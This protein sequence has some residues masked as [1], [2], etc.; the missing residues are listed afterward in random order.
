MVKILKYFFQSSIKKSDD[1]E[2]YKHQLESL[3]K[4]HY[5]E[6][7]EKIDNL[8]SDVFNIMD[9]FVAYIDFIKSSAKISVLNGYCK[10]TIVDNKYGYV[11]ATKMR[12]PIVER[13]IDYEYVPHDIELGKDLKG[14]LMYGLNSSG[15]TVIMKALGLSIIMAQCGLYV[16]AKEFILSPYHALYTRITGDDNI[17]RGLSSY[18][19][20]MSELNSIL[21][22]TGEFTMVIGDEVCRGTESISGNA[23]VASAII[24][25]A[26]TNSSFIF[27]T[28]LHEIMGLKDIKKLTNVKAFHLNVSYDEKSDTLIYDRII[29]EGSGNN[30]YGITVARHIIQDKEF[31][32]KANEIKNELLE[33]TGSIIS[34]K[35][36][37]Y[38]SNVYISECHV[39]GKKDKNSHISN[40]ETHHINFQKDCE[41]GLVKDK[42]HLK[43]NQEAN[44]IVLCN[45]CHDKIHSGKLLLDKYVMTSKG[46]NIIIKENK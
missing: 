22:R 29:K 11:C 38:N 15:K 39:C 37:R 1:I 3:N 21:K 40:L 33:Q 31:I 44:L 9:N 43:K 14:M 8:F 19:L 41:N 28:H 24:K 42:K 17:F 30:L 13:I 7:L 23:I 18:T 45:E 46:K 34:T 5:I 32:D 6:E 27:A 2:K 35:T 20:E 10:P 25:L 36:S 12:H 16:P 4:F 26:N